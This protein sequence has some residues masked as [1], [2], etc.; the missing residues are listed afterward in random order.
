MYLV[1]EGKVTKFETSSSIFVAGRLKKPRGGGNPPPPQVNRVKAK[2]KN[3]RLYFG[4]KKGGRKPP[5]G[6][7]YL[8]I[9]LYQSWAS[10]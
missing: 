9:E 4:Q 1:V 8:K 6:G 5:S 2:V 3:P 10:Q 7:L